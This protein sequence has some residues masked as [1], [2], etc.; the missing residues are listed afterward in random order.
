MADNDNLGSTDRSD[1]SV[2]P[3]SGLREEGG[4][5]GSSSTERDRGG[6]GSDSDKSYGDIGTPHERSETGSSGDELG[7]SSESGRSGKSGSETG[8]QGDGQNGNSRS[9][10]SDSTTSNR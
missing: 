7:G 2:N 9:T 1:E 8:S 6:L 4:M 10:G 5:S 3:D